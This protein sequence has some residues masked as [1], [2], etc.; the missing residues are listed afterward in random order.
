MPD[1]WEGYFNRVGAEED[2]GS[3]RASFLERTIENID[4]K[5]KY[6]LSYK[7][8]KVDGVDEY[9]VIVS[10][11]ATDTKTFMCPPGKTIHCGALI[12]YAD[13]KWLVTELDAESE[14]YQK[15]KIRQC[16]YI[17]R[18]KNKRGEIIER[19][20]IIDDGTK[21]L[22]GEQQREFMSYGD[23]RAQLIIAKDEET[24]QLRRGD[25]FLVDEDGLD[26]PLAFVLTKPNRISMQYKGYGVYRHMLTEDQFNPK[27]DN[28]ELMIAD[29]YS[30]ASKN[31]S[32]SIVHEEGWL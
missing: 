4:T 19:D 29:Y 13:Y 26:K 14:V 22:T 16:N 27:A 23:S 9:L 28:A 20:C 32:D 18:W 17:L 25:R 31:M 30:D 8:V 15:G 24:S 10:A 5:E 11:E 12:D 1:V 3:K 6:S 7:S 21:Y 2:A